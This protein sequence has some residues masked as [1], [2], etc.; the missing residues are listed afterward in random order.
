MIPISVSHNFKLL[1]CDLKEITIAP[2][3]GAVGK[4]RLDKLRKK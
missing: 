4:I 3:A 2:Q 1:K